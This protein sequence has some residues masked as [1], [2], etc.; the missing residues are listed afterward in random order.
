MKKLL[1]ALLAI[2]FAACSKDSLDNMEDY[3]P[4][5]EY[6]TVF[7]S[8]KA[9]LAKNSDALPI[10]NLTV[11]SAS[12]NSSDYIAAK[13]EIAD[14]ERRTNGAFSTMF[15]CRVKYRGASAMIYDKKSFALKLTDAVGEELKVGI[16][17]LRSDDSWILDAMAADRLRMRNRLNFDLWNSFSSTPYPTDYNQ[18]N[19]T[20]GL[21]VELFI[22]GNY[23]GLYCLSDKVNR[24]LLGLKK[25]KVENGEPTVH[26]VLYKCRRWALGAKLNGYEEQDMNQAEWNSWEL[27]YPDEYPC[28]AAYTP[29]KE[30]IDF[31]TETDDDTFLADYEKHFYADNLIDYEMF[32]FAV[33][34]RDNALKN[35]YLSAVDINKEQRFLITP[36]DLDCSLGG[37]YDGNYFDELAENYAQSAY[38]FCRLW[39][40]DDD[41]REK[42]SQR[43]RTLDN[44]GA[45]S[46]E[47]FNR[48]VD[49][50]VDQLTKSGAWQREHERWNNNPVPLADDLNTE[51]NYVKDWYSRNAEN[52]RNTEFR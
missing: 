40:L 26:G 12:V 43:W 50:Y 6:A 13:L 7:D 4:Q 51:A 42:M 52:L 16:L 11:D 41:F 27:K 32:L 29:L 14:R 10:L 44:G 18:R 35:T 9:S 17:G 36:W 22:N 38:P 15:D 47:T 34:L 45:L 20:Q 37:N 3:Q 31:C 39:P 21:F 28:E 30:L 24:K 33:G 23:H 46:V 49:S 1:F 25:I 2:A 19:G 48:R 5:E 8:L